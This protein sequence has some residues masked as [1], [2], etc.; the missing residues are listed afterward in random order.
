MTKF[1]RRTKIIATFVIVVILGYG[2]AKF[3]QAQNKVPAAFTVARLQGA[4]IAQEIVGN[5]NQSTAELEAISAYDEEGNY[6]KALASTTDMINQS[7]GLRNEAVQLSAQVSEMTADLPQITSP[8]AQQAALD[9]I[10]SQLAL[11]NELVTYSNDLDR[12][13]A[14]LQSRFAGNLVP[15]TQVSAIVTQVNVDVTAINNFNTQA[16]QAMAKFDSIEKN[17]E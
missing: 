13:L 7:A 10:S 3:W 12:L 4:I 11:M 14:V 15:D 1:S 2:I 17:D 9:S 5:S 6:S 16:T 8:T